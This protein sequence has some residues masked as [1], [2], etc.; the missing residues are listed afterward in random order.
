MGRTHYPKVAVLRE[1]KV[2]NDSWEKSGRYEAYV[3]ENEE[4]LLKGID[5]REMNEAEMLDPAEWLASGAEEEG[6]EKEDPSLL[7][8]D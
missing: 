5:L 3:S 2:K 4:V 7:G 8:L 1:T 6:R